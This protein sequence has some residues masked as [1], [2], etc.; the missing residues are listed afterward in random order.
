LSCRARARLLPVAAAVAALLWV[1][2]GAW[3][4]GSSLAAGTPR[5]HAAAVA[6]PVLPVS[7]AALYA[8]Q[9]GQ[10]LVADNA[11]RRLAIAS[12]TKLMTALITLQRV[13]RLGTVFTQNDFYPSAADSQ[14]GLVP[15]ERMSVHDLLLA[16]MLPSA[17]DAAEDLAYN[18][19]H[20]SLARFVAM[21]NAQARRLHLTDTHYSTPIGLDTPS[22]FSSAADLVRLADYDLT[23][24]AYFA[25]IVALPQAVLHSG[26]EPRLVMNLN[27]LVGRYRWIDGVKTGHTADAGYVLVASGHR[28]GMLLISAVLGT[29]DEAERDASTLALLNYGFRNFV[30]ST[31]VSAGEVLAR[32]AIRDRP[33]THAIV[34]A[35]S[36]FRWLLARGVHPHVRISVPSQLAGPLPAGAV[37]GTAS[38]LAGGRVLDRVPLLL[39]DRLQAVSSLTI[40]ASFITRPLTVIVILVIIGLGGCLWRAS[41]RRRLARQR[42]KLKTA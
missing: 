41:R 35:A 21:M 23:H 17:D 3:A 13:H 12:T 7:A 19:G 16:M 6:A 37:V 33:G 42:G 38:V 14:I 24:S 31:P 28:D 1:I 10:L 11:Y 26:S 32:P 30:L 36:S 39:A 27:D 29:A 34:R 25:R 22:N 2:V 15:G 9:T 18:V 40:A 20:G 8:P 5:A 4:P